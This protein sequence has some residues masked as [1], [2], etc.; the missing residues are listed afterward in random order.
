MFAR[1]SV[2]DT[3][4]S[5]TG[6]GSGT[7]IGPLVGYKLVTKEGLTFFAHIGA[8]YLSVHADAQSTTSGV[9]ASAAES[10]W[11]GLLNLNLGWS[12]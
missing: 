2:N 9:S 10:R 4:Q 3:G 5:V 6:F 7:A 8:Q 1:V 11:I 12:F